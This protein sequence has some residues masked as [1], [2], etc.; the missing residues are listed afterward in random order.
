[1]Q[2]KEKFERLSAIHM[3]ITLFFILILLNNN[4]IPFKGLL[5]NEHCLE[6]GHFSE[7]WFGK[8]CLLNTLFTYIQSFRC[9]QSE[10]LPGFRVQTCSPLS[11][12]FSW[13]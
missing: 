9:N 8:D 6:C 3:H 12:Y 10:Q 2:V 11:C 1:M 13:Y 4:K 7:A 5:V